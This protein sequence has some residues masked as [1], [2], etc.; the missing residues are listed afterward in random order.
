MLCKILFDRYIIFLYEHKRDSSWLRYV[1]VQ[2]IIT[3]LLTLRIAQKDDIGLFIIK[4]QTQLAKRI[5]ESK[6]RVEQYM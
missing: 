2:E 6:D 5:E 1:L 4:F 3:I